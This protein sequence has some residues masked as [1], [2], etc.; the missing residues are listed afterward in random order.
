MFKKK[1]VIVIVAVLLLGV[2]WYSFG[3]S[4]E[5]TEESSQSVSAID[6]E[7][8]PS[9]QEVRELREGYRWHDS[10]KV[11]LRLQVPENALVDN[12]SNDRLSITYLGPDNASEVMLEDGFLVTFYKDDAVERF[13]SVQAYALEQQTQVRSQGLSVT[14]PMTA[15]QIEGEPAYTFG[16]ESVLGNT[17]MKVFL[18]PQDD[19]GYVIS[20]QSFGSSTNAYKGMMKHIIESIEYL[21]EEE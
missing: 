18:L 16:H 13:S 14:V 3:G 5:E 7:T 19:I 10:K 9:Q 15:T 21:S 4:N 8:T 20:Y 1:K 17:T 12:P 6:T 2:G 11:S